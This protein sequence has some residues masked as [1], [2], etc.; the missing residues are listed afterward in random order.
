MTGDD[1]HKTSSEAKTYTI[2]KAD[3]ST[4]VSVAGGESFTYDGLAHPATVAVT[5][6]GGLNQS[7]EIGRASGR[8]RMKVS[9][10]GVSL[11]KKNAGDG[12]HKPSSETKTY[13]IAQSHSPK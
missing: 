3:S 7:P 8:G 10:V 1:N 2:A 6:V 13:T 12:N 11:K 4:V 5:G 9:G